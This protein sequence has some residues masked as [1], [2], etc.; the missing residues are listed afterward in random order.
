M[1]E[2]QEAWVVEICV[3]GR[4]KQGP[5]HVVIQN[6][7]RVAEETARDWNACRPAGYSYRVRR[8]IPAPEEVKE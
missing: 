8:Y 7:K 6:T 1:N 3:L 5:W 2:P 4:E